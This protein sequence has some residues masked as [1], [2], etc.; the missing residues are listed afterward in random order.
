MDRAVRKYTSLTSYWTE[1]SGNIVRGRSYEIRRGKKN[2]FLAGLSCG[3][4]L[5]CESTVESVTGSQ[6]SVWVDLE[7][8][9]R[10]LSAITYLINRAPAPRER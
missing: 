8:C 9:A 10:I 3:E 7:F 1:R 4:N 6:A 2:K 5:G